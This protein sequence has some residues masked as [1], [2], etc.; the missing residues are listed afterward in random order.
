MRNKNRER[1]PEKEQ[2]KS[3]PIEVLQWPLNSEEV[4]RLRVYNYCGRDVVDL[5]VWWRARNGQY[6][7]G[8]RGLTVDVRHLPKLNKGFKNARARAR[9]AGLFDKN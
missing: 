9:E 1:K 2:D 4:I 3:A 7:P 8:P 5:R 6:L